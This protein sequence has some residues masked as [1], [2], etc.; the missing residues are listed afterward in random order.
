[1]P[2]VAK[3]FGCACR[4]NFRYGTK[5]FP[6]KERA[7]FAFQKTADGEEM[8]FFAMRSQEY[9]SD[10]AEPNR[11]HAYLSYIDSLKVFQPSELRTKV[12]ET[13]FFTQYGLLI[14]TEWTFAL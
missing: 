6:Y 11:G 3:R 4:C 8:V 13:R 9:G 10:C 1:M 5:E 14:V 7:I 2:S 12:S